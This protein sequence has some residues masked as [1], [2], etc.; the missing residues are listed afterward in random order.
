MSDSKATD[1]T[2]H[3]KLTNSG[4]GILAYKI[5]ITSPDKFRVKPGTGILEPGASVQ[6]TINFLK[7]F[8]TSPSNN[9]DK[10]L[11]LWTPTE[12]KMQVSELNE[13]WK[14]CVLK[15]VA[16]KEHK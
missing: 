16:I 12:E 11:I 5:K 4:Q 13:F 3:I 15:K 9:R 6:I 8:H 10:F 7:E 1:V 14:Q 2:R